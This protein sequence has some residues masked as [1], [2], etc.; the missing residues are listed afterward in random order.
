MKFQAKRI[1]KVD[2]DKIIY[3]KYG[4]R[5]LTY[6]KLWS[7]I[8]R[9]HVPDFPP[10][11]DF[12]LFDK[13]NQ[14]CVM[15]ARNEKLHPNIEYS[16]NT[17]TRFPIDLFK[18]IIDE[19][20]T[21]NLYSVNFGAFAEPFVN[22]ECLNMVR[23]AHDQGIVDSRLITN[24]LLLGKNSSEIFMSGLTQLFISVDA[25]TE[26]TYEKIRGKGFQHVV[27]NTIHFL[28]ERSKRKTQLPI[29]RVSFVEMEMNK[30]EK[31]DF[32]KFWADKADFIDIQTFQNENEKIGE[33]LKQNK[34]FDC[35]S[36][37]GRISVLSDGS[38]I[39][40]CN[41]YGRTLK[42]GNAFH[43]TIEDIWKSEKMSDVRK[44]LISGTNTTCETCQ[45]A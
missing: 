17:K 14:S 7:S 26:K 19:G 1:S 39:P 20:K 4:E 28:E 13:C 12:E 45:R 3:K 10:H 24:G 44:K 37:F 41:F 5:Y 23:Y 43:Q 31:D 33:N 30:N 34:K 15:C 21:K 32:I 6:R 18:K 22:P 8:S 40:C 25:L 38:V 35:D 29:V 42:I 2:P 11:I 16:I 36:P 27:Q 9:E